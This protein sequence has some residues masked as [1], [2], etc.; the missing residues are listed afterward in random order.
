MLSELSLNHLHHQQ[1]YQSEIDN[2]FV[3]QRSNEEASATDADDTGG[4]DTDD[5]N[6]DEDDDDEYHSPYQNKLDYQY[7][8]PRVLDNEKDN[9]NSND[10]DNNRANCDNEDGHGHN[11]DVN[12]EAVAAAPTLSSLLT[13]SNNPTIRK[14]SQQHNISSN[15]NNEKLV[16]YRHSH[17]TSRNEQSMFGNYLNGTYDES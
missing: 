11:V 12:E 4:E 13:L 9:K 1:H 2:G 6:D 7:E 3:V 16:V 17:L 5:D 15:A 14:N 10:N 8:Q